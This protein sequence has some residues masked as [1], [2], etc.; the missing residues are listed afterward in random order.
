MVSAF[1]TPIVNYRW[2]DSDDLNAELERVILESEAARSGVV[3]SNIGGWH[4]TTDFLSWTVPAVVTLRTRIE[5]L[6]RELN[7]VAF[8]GDSGFA[9]ERFEL[10]GWA[11][12]LRHGG[13]NSLHSHPNAFWSGVYYVNSNPAVDSHPFS[14]KLELVDPRPGASLTYAEHSRLYGR[15]MVNPAASQMIVF[16]AWLQ[17]FVHPYYGDGER[18]SV[19]FNIV[20]DTYTNPS[21]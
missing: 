5:H 2:P 16:P 10:D 15:F 14:G 18:I 21:S 20:L 9:V 13:Y 11:N 3:K 17:H 6:I 19:A 4:S 7:K 1:A 12:V 8:D